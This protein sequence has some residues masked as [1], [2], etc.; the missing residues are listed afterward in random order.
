MMMSDG[1]ERG[2]L[3]QPAWSM[4]AENECFGPFPSKQKQL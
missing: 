4:L 1:G 3:S 2:V